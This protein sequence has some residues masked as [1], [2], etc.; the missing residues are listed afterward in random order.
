MTTALVVVGIF[1]GGVAAAI[2]RQKGRGQFR[3]FIVGFFFHLIGLIVLF[4]PSV[5]RPGVMR[6]CPQ[7]AEVIKSEALICRFCGST[8]PDAETA[9]AT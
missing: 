1:F 2:A 5:P 3:W 9:Q 7:C 6:K 4:L 8:L